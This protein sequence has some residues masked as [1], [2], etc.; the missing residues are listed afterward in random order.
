MEIKRVLRAG[1]RF[2]TS[3][4]YRFSYLIYKGFY[5]SMPDIEFLKKKYRIRMGKELNL[6]NP[7]TFN[8]K[9]QWLKL[10]NRRPEYTLLVD[11]YRVR[12]FVSQRIGPE[13]LIPLLGVWDSPDQIDFSALPRQFVLK[14]NHNSGLGMCICRDKSRL[15][16]RKVRAGLRRGLKEDNFYEGREWPYKNVERKIICEKYMEDT[17][18]NRCNTARPEGLTDYKIFCFHGQPRL[19]MIATDRFTDHPAYNYFDNEFHWLPIDWGSPRSETLT[20]RKPEKFAEML[21]IAGKLSE[22]IPFVRVDLYLVDNQI[23]FGEMTFFDG[24]GMDRVSPE[25]W[26]ETLGSWITLPPKTVSTD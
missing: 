1:F 16:I 8:E 2:L 10:Y 24:G 19:T 7:R 21:D 22:G 26:D 5:K 3:S 18:E 11:K 12:E 14:C 9:L 20:V 25:S 15:N 6:E 4:D 23:Y 17:G 13:H